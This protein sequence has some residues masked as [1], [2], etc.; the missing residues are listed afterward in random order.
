MRT[1]ALLL[2]LVLVPGVAVAQTQAAGG[3]TTSVQSSAVTDAFN[4][5]DVL[6]KM[7]PEGQAHMQALLDHAQGQHLPTDV[8]LNLV[9]EG[10]VKG[11]A[12]TAILAA[13]TRMED[14]LQ[15]AQQTI[16][17]AGHADPTPQ[18]TT[19]AQQAMAQGVNGS[20]LAAVVRA[21]PKDRPL[22]AAFAALTELQAQ[23]LPVDQA[24][25]QVQARLQSGVPDAGLSGTGPATAAGATNSA[26]GL[27]TGTNASA[28]AGASAAGLTTAG[29]ATTGAGAAVKGRP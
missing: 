7:S 18:E 8:L 19:Q 24:V 2:A 11:Q 23:G 1:K 27:Q 12:E 10:Q 6:N 21:A 3:T 9:A 22:S 17:D 16:V 26:A 13:A 29:N 14:Q 28:G 20:Q 25:A 15:V 4:R 5:A